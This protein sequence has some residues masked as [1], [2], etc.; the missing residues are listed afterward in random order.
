MVEV[1]AEGGFGD[2]AHIAGHLSCGSGKDGS[3]C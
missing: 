1:K 2:H 3:E